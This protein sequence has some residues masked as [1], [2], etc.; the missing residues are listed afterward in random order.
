[1]LIFFGDAELD[2]GKLFLNFRK[3][4]KIQKPDIVVMRLCIFLWYR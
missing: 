4:I 1:M 2:S 3:P